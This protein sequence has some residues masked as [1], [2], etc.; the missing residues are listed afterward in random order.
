MKNDLTKRL[1]RTAIIAAIYAV[2]TVAIAPLS[3]MGVQ[4]RISEILVLLAVFDPLYIG[5]LTLGCLI[6]NLLGPNGPLDVILGTLATFISV[7]AIYLTGKIV[8]NYRAKLLIASIWPTLFNGL[9][10][11]W[12]LNM[13]Y[14]F[15]LVLSMGQVALGELVV[16]TCIGVPLF[17]LAGSR[18]KNAMT[19]K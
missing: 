2:V 12:M 4:F 7:Y 19:F 14:G 6:A 18:F 16:I 3:Y 1:T 15:P 5:G 8:K 9:I 10:I 17:L 11:G 13:L